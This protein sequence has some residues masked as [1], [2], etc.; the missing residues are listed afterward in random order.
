VERHRGGDPK[1][2]SKGQRERLREMGAEVSREIIR[3]REE[4]MGQR[5]RRGAGEKT[6]NADKWGWDKLPKTQSGRGEAEMTPGSPHP[7]PGGRVLPVTLPL[8]PPPLAPRPAARPQ[9][10]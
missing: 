10:P 3:D 2:E 1:R 6:W 8:F 5:E 7:L 9:S 4:E